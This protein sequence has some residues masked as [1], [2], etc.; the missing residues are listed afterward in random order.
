MRL[1]TLS[2]RADGQQLSELGAEAGTSHILANAVKITL[3]PKG[4]NVIFERSH[5][6]PPSTKDCVTVAKEIEPEDRFQNMGAR[7]ARHSRTLIHISEAS[8]FRVRELR[9]RYGRR[10]AP[11]AA[12]R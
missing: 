11:G 6:A 4:R 5:R 7:M 8:N 2:S 12:A 9:G 1:E 10:S 3:G